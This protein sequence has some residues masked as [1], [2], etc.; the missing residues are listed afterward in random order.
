MDD[1]VELP[2]K[3][4]HLGSSNGSDGEDKNPGLVAV[5]LGIPSM[6]GD[7]RTPYPLNLLLKPSTNEAGE[8]GLWPTE[9]ASLYGLTDNAGGSGQ[10]VGIIALG[11]GYLPSDLLA[12]TEGMSRLSPLVV[13]VSVD[14]VSNSF[15]GGTLSDEEIALDLQILAGLL[16]ASRIVVYFSPN[17]QA[18]LAQAIIAAT[19]DKINKPSVLCISWGS[20]EQYWS[21]PARDA[22]QDALKDAIE[23]KIT[24]VAA[25]GDLLAT[26]GMTDGMAHVLFPAS[27]PY[28]LACGGTKIILDDTGRKRANEMVWNDGLVGTG[29]GVSNLFLVPDYQ[30]TIVIP[31]PTAGERRGRGL[32]D[33]AAAA[34]QT[35]G[36]RIVVNGQELVKSGTSAATPLWSAVIALANARRGR[37]LGLIHPFLY[38]TPLL[39][40]PIVVGNNRRDGIGYYA[41]PGWNLCA[42]FGVPNGI[43]T[44]ETLAAMP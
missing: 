21:T 28:A 16:P 1:L 20:A 35:P 7:G 3:L 13:D 27:S 42:G 6:I 8:K 14:G 41:G 31:N 10:C 19:N 25:A 5:N 38:A 24:V 4:P 17:S 18:G 15:G 2:R 37:P 36:Y 30:E 23:A 39:C 44:I 43:H 32:P 22:V 11:G 12:A 26:A 9:I 33:V 34:A 29:G 40:Q